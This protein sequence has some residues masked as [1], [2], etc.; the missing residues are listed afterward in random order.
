MSQT[1]E[2]VAISL[3]DGVLS[4]TLKRR[5][6]N[7]S[8]PLLELLARGEVVAVADPQPI[9]SETDHFSFRFE[10]PGKVLTDGV[11]T[12]IVRAE[13]ASEGLASVPVAVGEALDGD[14]LAELDLLRAELDMLKKAFRQNLGVGRF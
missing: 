4:G 12:L 1:F 10:V 14:I 13:G 5:A 2:C 6:A 7:A 8:A 3:V 11:L 9:E